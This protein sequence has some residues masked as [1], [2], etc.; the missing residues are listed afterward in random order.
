MKIVMFLLLLLDDQ[1][2]QYSKLL[3]ASR[4]QVLQLVILEE[5]AALLKQYEEEKHTPEACFIEAAIQELKVRASL[6]VFS[7]F[8]FNSMLSI[9]P[10]KWLCVIVQVSVI[11]MLSKWSCLLLV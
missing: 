5:K 10:L 6:D 11:Y 1:H 7:N 9:L 2:S 4:E 8:I 3:L